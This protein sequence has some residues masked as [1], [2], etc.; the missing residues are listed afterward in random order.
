M[1]LSFD[2]ADFTYEYAY[3]FQA[4]EIKQQR[5]LLCLGHTTKVNEKVSFQS[6]NCKYKHI[7]LWQDHYFPDVSVAP[8]SLIYF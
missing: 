5:T 3:H 2:S 8:S 6:Y 4:L 7:Y 1:T